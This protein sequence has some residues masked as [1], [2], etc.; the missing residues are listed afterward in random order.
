MPDMIRRILNMLSFKIVHYHSKHKTAYI[1]ALILLSLILTGAGLY[2]MEFKSGIDNAHPLVNLNEIIKTG[3]SYLANDYTS[4]EASVSQTP[5][6]DVTA[7][8]TT[9]TGAEETPASSVTDPA[10]IEIRG[11]R[12]TYNGSEKTEDAIYAYIEACNRRGTPIT[13][14]NRY[15]DYKLFKRIQKFLDDNNI[16]GYEIKD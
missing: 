16:K 10:E 8:E 6:A 1:A 14:D 9:D 7:V 2:Q 13:I 12:I 4:A 11:T 15:A 5:G 3:G